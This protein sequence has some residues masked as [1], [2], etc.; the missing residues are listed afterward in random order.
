MRNSQ[1]GVPSES[2]MKR[3][4]KSAAKAALHSLS[5]YSNA[6]AQQRLDRLFEASNRAAA[7][8]DKLVENELGVTSRESE[9]KLIKEMEERHA[10]ELQSLRDTFEARFAAMESIM[11]ARAS[12]QVVQVTSPQSTVSEPNYEDE[13]AR[14]RGRENVAPTAVTPQRKSSRSTAGKTTRGVSP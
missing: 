14:K 12:V 10:R 3:A 7:A 6:N 8:L 9:S 11:N 13:S 5:P 2:D 4:Q 1:D